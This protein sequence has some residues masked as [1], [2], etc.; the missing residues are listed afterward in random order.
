MK[1]EE[2]EERFLIDAETYTFDLDYSGYLTPIY[3]EYIKLGGKSPKDKFSKNLGKFYELT[4]D[5]YMGYCEFPSREEAM[6][7][8]Y[9]F[10]RSIKEGNRYFDAVDNIMCYT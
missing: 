10:I 9:K 2:K 3:D 7:K 8:W 5:S 6:D 1:K 4:F